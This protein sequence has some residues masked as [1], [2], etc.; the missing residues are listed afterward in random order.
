MSVPNSAIPRHALVALLVRAE[1]ALAAG[2]E[3]QAERL[4][5]D[6]H[7]FAHQDAQLHQ[8]VHRREL[9]LARRRG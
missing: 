1:R 8:A 9:D 5:S 7:W 3:A 4:L 6:L 2:D